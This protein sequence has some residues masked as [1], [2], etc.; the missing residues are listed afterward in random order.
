MLRTEEVAL[1]EAEAI[2]VKGS[3]S[4]VSLKVPW[5]L[6]GLAITFAEI[7]T[8]A[9]ESTISTAQNPSIGGG[10]VYISRFIVYGWC[11]GSALLLKI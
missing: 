6:V 11:L 1:V 9:A 5:F 7:I 2:L 3:K 8:F 10:V 4:P